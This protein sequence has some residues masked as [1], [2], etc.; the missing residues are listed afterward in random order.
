VALAVALLAFPLRTVVV[1]GEQTRQGTCSAAQ[2]VQ[3]YVLSTCF[4]AIVEKLLA[5]T[6]R[7]DANDANLRTSAYEALNTM[8]EH[9]PVDCYQ[10]VQQTTMVILTRISSTLQIGSAQVR[11][12]SA[13][14]TDARCC[15]NLPVH[16]ELMT[17]SL[18]VPG[19]EARLLGSACAAVRNAP[20]HLAAA[21][22]G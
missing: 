14:D 15:N 7:A 9:S 20:G 13:R 22:Q 3:T 4:A 12:M 18:T 8:L 1:A 21:V 5:T 19:R 17:P 10:C 16:T 11:E 2:D 6:E